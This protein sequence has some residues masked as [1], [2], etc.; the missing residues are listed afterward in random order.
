MHAGTVEPDSGGIARMQAQAGDSLDDPLP[1]GAV[2]T[3]TSDVA[4]LRDHGDAR[5]D[6]ALP[7]VGQLQMF[8]ADAD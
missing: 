1:G 3:D 7:G 2:T 4:R 6:I 5:F 8:R